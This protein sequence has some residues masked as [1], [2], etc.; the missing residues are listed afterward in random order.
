ME[1]KEGTCEEPWGMYGSA[2]PLFVHLKLTSP[3]M[4]TNGDLNLKQ[5]NKTKSIWGILWEEQGLQVSKP[6]LQSASP[7]DEGRGTGDSHRTFPSIL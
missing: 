6:T 1:T 2:E 5:T 3:W 7:T 4:L